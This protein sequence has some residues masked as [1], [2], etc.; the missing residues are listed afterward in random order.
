[1]STTDATDTQTA[2]YEQ[3]TENGEKYAHGWI[4]RLQQ[5]GENQ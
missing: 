5:G 2:E 4:D 1:M 3:Q